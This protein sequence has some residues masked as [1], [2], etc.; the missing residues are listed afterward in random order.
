MS[1]TRDPRLAGAWCPYCGLPADDYTGLEG[2][3]RPEPGDIT[4]VLCCG[5][6]ARFAGDETALKLVAPQTAELVK[7]LGDRGVRKAL[8]LV[9]AYRRSQ[10]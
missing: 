8:R 4:V 5:R 10:S 6:V 9:S 1:A 2:D 3:E 7:L